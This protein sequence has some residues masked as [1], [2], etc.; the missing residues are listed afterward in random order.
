MDETGVLMDLYLWELE[1]RSPDADADEH[2]D[3]PCPLRPWSD[4]G[5]A[6]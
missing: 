1:L 5:P 2:A 4:S 3:G 6:R